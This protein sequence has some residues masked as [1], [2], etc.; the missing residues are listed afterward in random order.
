MK[1]SCLCTSSRF[2]C[3]FL[4]SDLHLWRMKCIGERKGDQRSLAY[5][6]HQRGAETGNA[7]ATRVANAGIDNSGRSP[8]KE[9]AAELLGCTIAVGLQVFLVSDFAARIAISQIV[10]LR[11]KVGQILTV[12]DRFFFLPIHLAQSL[13]IMEGDLGLCGL[14]REARIPGATVVPA[15]AAASRPRVGESGVDDVIV[16]HAENQFVHGDS[17][18]KVGFSC[19]TPVGGVVE[20]KQVAHLRRWKAE[21]R[22]HALAFLKEAIRNEAVRIVLRNRLGFRQH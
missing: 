5:I 21:T 16:G 7:A 10:K 1:G 11:A 14:Q 20:L 13:A 18:E 22:Q 2:Y 8:I 6:A 19:Q 3:W 17:G 15:E 4:A 9:S 12:V